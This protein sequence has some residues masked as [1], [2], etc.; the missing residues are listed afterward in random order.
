[1]A[2][3]ERPIL[4]EEVR[5]Y[6]LPPDAIYELHTY[7]RLRRRSIYSPLLTAF[8]F[9]LLGGAAFTLW[10]SQPDVALKQW[11]LIGISVDS[12]EEG[13]SII[14]VVYVNISLDI[15]LQV[16]NPNFVGVV[17]DFLNV[18]ILYRGFEI[19]VARLKGGRIQA[20]SIVQLPAILNLQAR[21]I[22]ENVSELLIDVAHREVPL[23]THMRIIGAVEFLVLRPHV[24]VSNSCNQLRYHCLFQNNYTGLVYCCSL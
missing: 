9:F 7:P 18:K 2:Q 17:Y 4:V 3:Q 19:G 20:R 14:P 5:Y 6:T 11:K 12:K 15:V 13:R 22:L 10:P 24:D 16:E 1:M 8:F 21:E 23:T